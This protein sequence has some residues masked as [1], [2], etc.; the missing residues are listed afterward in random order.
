[1]ITSSLDRLSF[2]LDVFGRRIKDRKIH[3]CPAAVRPKFPH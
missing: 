2:D 3:T 1:M